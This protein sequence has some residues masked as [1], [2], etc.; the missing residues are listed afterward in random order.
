MFKGLLAPDFTFIKLS[1][2]LLVS[3]GATTSNKPILLGFSPTFL[4]GLYFKILARP[5][6][7]SS[8]L[9]FL[10]FAID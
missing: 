10:L 3:L 6:K 7:S 1:S 9:I 5:I 4:T 8:G 2:S